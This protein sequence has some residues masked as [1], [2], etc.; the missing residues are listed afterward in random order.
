MFEPM[1]HTLKHSFGVVFPLFKSLL[2]F[3]TKYGSSRSKY[4]SSWHLDIEPA[5]H[6]DKGLFLTP[7]KAYSITVLQCRTLL[8]SQTNVSQV[9]VLGYKSIGQ[10]I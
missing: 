1:D 5:Y 8:V 4:T 6:D 3:R 10:C 2:H 7:S 9:F